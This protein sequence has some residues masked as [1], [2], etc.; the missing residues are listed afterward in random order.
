[1]NQSENKTKLKPL[2]PSSRNPCSENRTFNLH[3]LLV[4]WIHC[5]LDVVLV[6]LV[7]ELA[8][9]LLGLWGGRVCGN[10]ARR[11]ARGGSCCS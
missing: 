10:G 9:G 8:Y 3:S 11:S 2:L 1:M 6:D 4:E 5:C 7:H